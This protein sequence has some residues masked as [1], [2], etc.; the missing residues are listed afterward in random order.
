MGPSISESFMLEF[1]KE[2]NEES[3]EQE[4]EN[5]AKWKRKQDRVKA[6]KRKQYGEKKQ[7][8]AGRLW[9]V[10]VC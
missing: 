5:H 9:Y 1:H 3:N 7:L 10:V 4:L 8:L 6:N 2:E